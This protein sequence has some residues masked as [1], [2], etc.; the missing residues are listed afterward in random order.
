[1]SLRNTWRF[2]V[3]AS[4]LKEAAGEKLTYHMERD[5]YWG[6][7]GDDAEEKLLEAGLLA[8]TAGDRQP[9]H[10]SVIRDPK[11]KKFLRQ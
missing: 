8:P 10:F 4:D 3:S 1:M 5:I 7:E 2:E 9:W 6:I 11:T